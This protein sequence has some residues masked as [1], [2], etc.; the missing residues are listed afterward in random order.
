MAVYNLPFY[1]YE[2]EKYGVYQ[3]HGEERTIE[4][5][6]DI[7]D[8]FRGKDALDD[9][10]F[11][12]SEI[13]HLYDVKVLLDRAAV[14]AV[15]SISLL[16]CIMYRSHRKKI[17][18]RQVAGT[19]IA[20]GLFAFA[21]MVLGV[22]LC[23]ATGFDFLFTAFHKVFFTGNYAFNPAISNMKYMFPD[24]F[25]LDIS[26]RILSVYLLMSALAAL[27]GV[28]IRR[29]CSRPAPASP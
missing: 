26:S 19:L 4:A 21:M 29:R 2:F 24:G 11:S 20:A 27:G 8:Y 15:M 17:L 22:L 23:F 7:M 3:R 28:I 16:V 18:C 25:F 12:Y 9:S 5:A 1:R 13:S 6:I 10:F 14:L